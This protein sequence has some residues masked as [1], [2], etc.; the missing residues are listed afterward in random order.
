MRELET[1]ELLAEGNTTKQIAEALHISSKT[2]ETHRANL[3][4]KL[5]LRNMPELM[6]YAVRAGI[7]SP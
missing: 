3:M 4:K 5:N 7:I 1:L 6:R 2:A